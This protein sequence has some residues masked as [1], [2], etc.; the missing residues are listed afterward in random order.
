V[1]VVNPENRF[2]HAFTFL[3]LVEAQELPRFCKKKMQAVGIEVVTQTL[4]NKGS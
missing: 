2:P 3:T 1:C 4:Q